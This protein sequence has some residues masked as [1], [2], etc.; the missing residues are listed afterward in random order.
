MYQFDENSFILIVDG[1]NYTV[2]N[3]NVT[4]DQNNNCYIFTYILD[5]IPNYIEASFKGTLH[6]KNYDLIPETINL[7]LSFSNNC[8]LSSLT[9]GKSAIM[10]FPPNLYQ[11]FLSFISSSFSYIEFNSL[12]AD[13]RFEYDL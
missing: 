13:L 3:T 5:F 8:I 11:P 6:S 10:L 12:R 7:S 1:I 4:Y 9:T 2:D